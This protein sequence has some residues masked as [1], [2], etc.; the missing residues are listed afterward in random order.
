MVN[1]KFKHNIKFHI[2]RITTQKMILN[3]PILIEYL[4][5]YTYNIY[6]WLQRICYGING[7]YG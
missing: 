7:E 4:S 2:K 5:I 3:D 1:D 6:V